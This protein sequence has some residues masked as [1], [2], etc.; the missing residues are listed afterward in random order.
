MKDVSMEFLQLNHAQERP[1]GS[2]GRWVAT[3]GFCQKSGVKRWKAESESRG[4]I[5]QK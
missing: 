3:Q 1:L 5:G 2:R 4:P